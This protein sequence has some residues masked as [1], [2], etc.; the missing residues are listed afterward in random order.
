MKRLFGF[1]LCVLIDVSTACCSLPR[2]SRFE[3]CGTHQS[4]R[5]C[6][7][8]QQQQESLTDMLW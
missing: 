7:A 1:Y 3:R 2:H 5:I 6:D 8:R 4:A